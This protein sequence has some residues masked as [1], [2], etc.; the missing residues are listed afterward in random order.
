MDRREV[1]VRLRCSEK[2]HQIICQLSVSFE[3]TCD[4]FDVCP[5]IGERVSEQNRTNEGHVRNP[6]VG[7]ACAAV[8]LK[9]LFG[10]IG[11]HLGFQL[12]LGM[13]PN[14]SA[15]ASVSAKRVQLI[16]AA[17]AQQL[18]GLAKQ[19]RLQFTSKQNIAPFFF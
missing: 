7:S 9:S 17:F 5:W 19:Q 13:I 12:F 6:G 4:L 3:H 14:G 15:R 18:P 1:I 2:T 10:K 11:N 8:F 16:L